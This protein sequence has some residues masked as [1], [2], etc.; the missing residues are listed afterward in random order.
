MQGKAKGTHAKHAERV[1]WPRQTTSCVPFPKETQCRKIRFKE[2]R[3]NGVNK[4]KYL[5]SGVFIYTDDGFYQ[6]A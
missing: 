2:A 3:G 5:N 6:H 1:Y 4:R